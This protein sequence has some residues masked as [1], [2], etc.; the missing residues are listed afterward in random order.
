MPTRTQPGRGTAESQAGGIGNGTHPQAAPPAESSIRSRAAAEA[1]RLGSILSWVAPRSPLLLPVLAICV[2]FW[3]G[4]MS[5][6]TLSQ[7]DQAARTIPINDQHA[8]ILIWLWRFVWPLG[9]DPGWIFA[10]QTIAF[11]LGA[12]LIARVAF[13]PLGSSLVTAAVMFSP[14]VFGSLALIG[15]DVWF[16]DFLLLTFGLLAV[17]VRVRDRE[18]AMR[19]ALG[20]AVVCAFFCLAARQ[21][22]ASSIVVAAVLIAALTLASR[23]DRKCSFVRLAAAV[24]GGV[25]LTLGLLAFQVGFQREVLKVQS[26]HPEQYLYLYDLAAFSRHENRDAFPHS[27]YRPRDLQTIETTTSADDI[28]AIAFNSDTETQF[29]VSADQVADMRESWIDQITGH[30][31]TYLDFRGEAWLRQI[32]LTRK[33]MWIY[34]PFIDPNPRGFETE[35][36]GANRVARGYEDAFANP[37]NEGGIVHRAWIYLLIDA[38]C[39]AY[40]LW[41][42]RTLA[43][44]VVGALGVAAWTHQIG[45]FFGTMGTG[46]RFE[47]PAVAI[48]MLVVAVTVRM[49]ITGRRHT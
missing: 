26:V 30:P 45:L 20:G 16:T 8:P 1:L 46:F 37:A 11:A 41:R 28:T 36:T 48:A 27:V 29:P 18:R 49:A 19:W 38:V 23:L 21:N 5:A 12:Y 9:I 39:A 25:A 3:P 2:G 47:F 13:G 15:R 14:P 6:D 7:I 32:G 10:A 33:P 40:L 22:A 4:N 24:G 17:A 31:L 42:R 35:F 34:H 43:L 44:A